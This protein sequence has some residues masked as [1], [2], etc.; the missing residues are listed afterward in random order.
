MDFLTV[1]RAKQGS[2][3]GALWRLQLV[4]VLAFLFA[5]LREGPEYSNAL[6]ALSE[7]PEFF[8]KVSFF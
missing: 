1:L 4:K 3:L 8:A 6:L 5:V 2:F 7:N